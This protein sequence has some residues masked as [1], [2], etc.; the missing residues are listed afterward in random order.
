MQT[1]LRTDITIGQL[2]EGFVYNETEGKGLFGL[3][4]RLT[5][6]PEYQRNYIYADGKRD[7]AVIQSILQGYPIGLLYFNERAD[8]QLEV[9]DGQQRITSIG[10][11]VS[12]KLPVI[13][14]GRPSYFH[15][16]SP[17][18]KQRIVNTPLLIYICLG[19]E[20]EIKEWFKTINIAGVPLNEQELLNAVYSGPF[21]SAL[22]REFSN[23]SNPLIQQRES[24][25]KGQVNRQEHLAAVLEWVSHGR[26]SEY[27]SRHRHSDSIRGVIEH[28]DRVVGW[29]DDT[30]PRVYAEMR[31]L[32]WGQLYDSYHGSP[33][34][35]DQ[36]GQRV[37]VLMGDPHVTHKRGIFEYVLGGGR[38]TRLLQVRCF[39]EATKRSV[40]AA[41]TA[42]ARANG[43]SNCH[44]CALANGPNHDRIWALKDME[45]DHVT[46]WS[47]GGETT[48]GN[49][50]VLCRTHNRAKGNG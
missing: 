24:Y 49:C 15:G 38:D 27:M 50:Q 35:S 2:C 25:I 18:E 33:Y 5:I 23:S 22:K 9:L 36:I 46:P 21:V 31:G 4:G 19:E 11:Y 45:A 34:D 26:V 3:G 37:E 13:N 17:E 29:I 44:L 43:H 30:F 12:G 42:A 20:R 39:D 7:V 6:Q 1:T 40:Y 41:Q 16:L 32:P 10:R 28:F 48:V 47:R 8:G 14:H